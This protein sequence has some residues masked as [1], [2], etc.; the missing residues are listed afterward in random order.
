MVFKLKRRPTNISSCRLTCK[1]VSDILR[2]ALRSL[3]TLAA[4]YLTSFNI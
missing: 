1:N 3:I 4:P 2:F